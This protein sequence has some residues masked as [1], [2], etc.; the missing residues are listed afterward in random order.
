MIAEAICSM[1]FKSNS[2]SI[3]NHIY[4]VQKY[5]GFFKGELHFGTLKVV[6]II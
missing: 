4:H 3:N 5:G 6:L 1:N 2:S